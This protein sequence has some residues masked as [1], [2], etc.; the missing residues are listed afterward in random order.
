M[1]SSRFHYY[2]WF[3]KVMSVFIDIFFMA[4]PLASLYVLTSAFK[5]TLKFALFVLLI[6]VYAAVIYFF[7][8]KV[9]EFLSFVLRKIAEMDERRMIV[10]ISAVMVII[11]IIATLLFS[12][13][14][15]SGGD[16]K[17]YDDIARQ[18]IATGDIHS[19]AISHL[20]GLALHFVVFELLSIPL[21]IGMFIV[22]YI[23]TIINFLSFKD[24]IGK[25]KAFFIVLVYVLMPSSALIS[26]CTTHEVFVYMY[27]SLFLFFY[28]KL[29]HEDRMVSIIFYT[30]LCILDTILTCFVNPG[31]YIIY[32][33]MVLTV[34]LSNVP[35]KK[36]GFIVL[37]LLLSV[38][39]SNRLSAYLNVNEHNTLINTY[40]ILIHGANPESLGEQIDGYPLRQMRM[41]IYDHTLD[42]S[43]E[44]FEV[45]AKA[46]L[47]ED[48]VY[49][50]KHPLTLIRLIVHKFYILW[51]GVHYPLELANYYG[52]MDGAVYFGLLGINVLIYLFMLTAGLVFKGEK[53]YDETDISNYKLEF[54]GVF[55][56]TMFCIVVNKYSLYATLFL[57]LISFYRA[58]VDNA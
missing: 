4:V 14:A 50:L 15:T 18:I 22:F 10:V 9:R 36:K 42:F 38:L 39:G 46:V 32:I 24:I 33:I 49:L 57:Y 35:F 21:H 25:D 19:D 51:S 11:K 28:N 20:Y 37:I 56:L 29:I 6:G 31:G 53:A 40:T 2:Y 44:G 55:G 16:I 12:Y 52:A 45:A 13:D 48:Y 5:G 17:I 23:G 26:F 41:W 34:L 43:D 1:E 54:L 7:K 47:I 30:L 27:V 8:D 3:Q 58:E